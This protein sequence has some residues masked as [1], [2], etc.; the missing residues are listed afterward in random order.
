MITH[1][2]RKIMIIFYTPLYI[3]LNVG[4]FSWAIINFYLFQRMLSINNT[5]KQ[6][7]SR[8][9]QAN[10]TDNLAPMLT[11]TADQ[12]LR[13]VTSKWLFIKYLNLSR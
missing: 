1:S 13:L 8:L 3:S 10:T 11:A 6:T 5:K 12:Q 9:S 2:E 7:T 4:T